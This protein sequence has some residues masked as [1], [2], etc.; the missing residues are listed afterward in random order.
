ME[1]GELEILVC[2]LILK[3]KKGTKERSESVEIS[4]QNFI[5]VTY[6]Y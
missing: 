5:A 6:C 1:Q 2:A 3:K 4:Y